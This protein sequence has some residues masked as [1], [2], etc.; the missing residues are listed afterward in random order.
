M[1]AS[2]T[3]KVGPVS[4][5]V[6]TLDPGESTTCTATYTITQA[7]VNA[8]SVDNTATAHGVPPTGPSVSS[9]PD[10]TSTPT[11]HTAT[12]TLDKIAGTPT[13]V[14]GNGLVDA[15]DTIAYSFAVT[16]T[17]VVTVTGLQVDDP[18]VGAVSCPTTTLDPGPVDHVCEDL[19]DHPG[20][21]RQRFRR[22]HRDR[23]RKPA[24]RPRGHLTAR[25]DLDP[26]G[27]GGVARLRQERRRS[28][29]RQRQRRWSMPVTP[30]AYSFLV[31]NT[32]V[33]TVHDVVVVDPLAGSAT[34]AAPRWPLT[35]P[36]TCTADAPYVITQ[37]DVDAG[38]VTNTAHATG[39]RPGRQPGR[40]A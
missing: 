4:C 35:P 18:K 8:G 21:R 30:I 26:D 38:A 25:L 14:N 29:R 15:G 19:H 32:G 10:S 20:R 13:D 28:R 5:P 36:T 16:N 27:V 2:P 31:T 22:Q 6:T 39:A 40:L 23:E 7:D 37:A 34:C 9:A 3:P 24:D 11:D 12:L 1:S 17:G 33:V